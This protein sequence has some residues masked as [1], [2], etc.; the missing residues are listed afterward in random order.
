MTV[1]LWGSRSERDKGL[2]PRLSSDDR[3]QLKRENQTSQRDFAQGI[4]FFRPGG[5]RPS[6][7][8]METLIEDPRAA[9]GVEPICSELPIAAST[10]YE[11]KARAA[12]PSRLP[13]R[14]RRD[15][16]LESEI[17]RV[18]EENFRVYGAVL[19]QQRLQLL[20]HR[21]V[22]N[23][24]MRSRSPWRNI[25]DVEYPKLEWVDWFNHKR[26]LEPIGDG[27]PAKKENAYYRRL[28][29]STMAA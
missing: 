7:E 24:M 29:E 17:Q 19:G 22:Q 13:Q 14:A 20:H 18:R 10:Y 23:G 11:Q 4:G 28:E 12:D 6:T 1:P 27:L 2:C 26:L 5:T 9:Y 8:I 15:S 16:V 25:D 21:L 3:E